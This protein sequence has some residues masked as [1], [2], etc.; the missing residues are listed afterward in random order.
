MPKTV[1]VENNSIWIGANDK[2]KR[3]QQ[4]VD[5]LLISI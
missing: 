5:I 3:Y 2:K 1:A 4:I